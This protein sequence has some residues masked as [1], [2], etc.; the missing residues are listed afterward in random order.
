MERRIFQDDPPPGS[1]ADPSAGPLLPAPELVLR[2]ERLLEE[3]DKTSIGDAWGLFKSA[4]VV[5]PDNGG[6]LAGMA[7][8]TAI[9]YSRRWDEDDGL[10]DQSQ[11]LARK[12]VDA[13][14]RDARS[15]AALAAVSLIAEEGET[16]YDEA[17]R[18]W[19][20]KDGATPAWVGETYAQSLIARGDSRA[21]LAVLEELRPA[22][23]ARYPTWFLEGIAH[24][25]LGDLDE[26]VLCLRRANILAPRFPA[27]L[28]VMARVYDRMGRR[29]YAT[30]LYARV[31]TDF[32]EESGRVLI[33][34]S[35]SLIG[36]HKYAEA[37]DGLDQVHFHTKRGLGEGTTIYL[38][39][40]CLDKLG[41]TDEAIPLYR[42]VAEEFPA[43]SYGAVT[44]ESLASASFEA[45]ARIELDR[46][47]QEEAVRLMEEALAKPR[48]TIGLFTRLASVYSDYKL[49]A[50]AVRVLRRAAEI[51]FGPRRAG[52]KATIYVVWAREAKSQAGGIEASTSDLLLALDR[53]AGTLRARGDVADFLE[54]ARACTLAGDN[55]RALSWMKLAV[56]RGY[57]HLDWIS[58]DAEM[59]PLSRDKGFEDLR[60]SLPLP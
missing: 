59:R 5:D 17:D 2:G 11:D 47:R 45:L 18:A 46:G 9:K 52:L 53:D 42:R 26:A 12:S 21:A 27:A 58:G 39:G 30:Q 56:D 14:P 38:K 16:A 51:D 55:G 60:R 23:P 43:A 40:L 34:M 19:S 28:L 33:L 13:S 35:A 57:R 44:S 8:A 50:E 54:A 48:P 32:P 41:R 3:P 49:H 6:A 25:E 15:H 37:M 22:Q 7:R 20:L 31:K 4:L 29:D 10:L 1:A 36:R 24:L